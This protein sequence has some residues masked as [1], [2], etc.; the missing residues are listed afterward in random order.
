M[1]FA[2]PGKYCTSAADP[3]LAVI[4]STQQD[5][6]AL[7]TQWIWSLHRNMR[8]SHCRLFLLFPRTLHG[9]DE[10]HVVSGIPSKVAFE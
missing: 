2:S 10:H 8:R 6:Y 7:A 5:F 9:R 4:V 3:S 1:Q